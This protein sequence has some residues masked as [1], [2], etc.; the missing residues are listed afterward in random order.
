MA[1][2]EQSSF[3]LGMAG[4]NAPRCYPTDRDRDAD[5]N[6][7]GPDPEVVAEAWRMWRAEVPFA[8][9]YV[10][11]A[12]TSTSSGTRAACYARCSCT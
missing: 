8:K 1:G 3:R 9:Q 4:Q 6:A 2:V 5:F 11:E 12:P 7:A 10:S